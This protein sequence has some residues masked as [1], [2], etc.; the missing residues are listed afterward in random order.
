MERGAAMMAKFMLI[1]GAFPGGWIWKLVASRLR[2]KD[3]LVIVT[4]LDRCGERAMNIRP[5]ITTETQAQ[6]LS[7]F[8]WSEDNPGWVLRWR[9]GDGSCRRFAKGSGRLTC[10]CRCAGIV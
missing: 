1:H 9:D 8:L 7:K 2:A 5:G 6:E 10:F 4:T 3:H